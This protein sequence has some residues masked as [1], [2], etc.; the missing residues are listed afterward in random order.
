MKFHLRTHICRI[1]GIYYNII[2]KL[3]CFVEGMLRYSMRC[4]SNKRQ[5]RFHIDRHWCAAAVASYM[6]KLPKWSDPICMQARR[7]SWLAF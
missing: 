3:F 2:T 1:I 7:P 5:W 6:E 4:E